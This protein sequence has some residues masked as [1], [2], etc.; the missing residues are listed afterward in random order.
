MGND[1]SGVRSRSQGRNSTKSLLSTSIVVVNDGASTSASISDVNAELD[2][3]RI[4]EIPHF[5]P[6]MQGVLPGYRDLPEILLK[7]DPRPIYRF[8]QRLQQHFR[9]C[10]EAVTTEQGRIFAHIVEIDQ[11]A[12]SL[13]KKVT[14]SNKKLDILGNELKKVVVISEQIDTAQVIYEV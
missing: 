4:K 14:N 13:V 12:L 8:L 10:T 3:R 7:I 2:L 6:L 5:L 9:E 11:L 1:Q